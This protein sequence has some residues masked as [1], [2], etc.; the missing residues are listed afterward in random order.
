[1]PQATSISGVG[2][3]LEGRQNPLLGESLVAM[4]EA[5]T[6]VKQAEK[7]QALQKFQ[8]MVS[9][10]DKLPIDPGAMR[11]AAKKA[12]IP[13]A[14]DDDIAAI[15]QA[16]KTE[17]GGAAPAKQNAQPASSSGA[18]P[19][20]G[21]QKQAQ[22]DAAVAA[23]QKKFQDEMTP[24]KGL[25]HMLD[26]WLA[27]GQQ[28]QGQ[29]FKSKM[30]KMEADEATDQYSKASEQ[31]KLK[32]LN[33]DAKAVGQAQAMALVPFNI[34]QLA[35]ANAST[36]LKNKA[37]EIALGYDEGQNFR[38]LLQGGK[39]VK[40]AYSLAHTLSMGQP[41]SPEQMKAASSMSFKEMGDEAST[42]DNLMQIGVPANDIS[43]VMNKARETGDLPGALPSKLT[44]I[45]T[46]QLD[47]HKKQIQ[48]DQ[49]RAG[50]EAKRV[51]LEDRRVS[52]YEKKTDA[53]V[54]NMQWKHEAAIAKLHLAEVTG[55]NKEYL[56]S[57]KTLITQK[58][59]GIEID[60]K[61]LQ[62]TLDG[63]K[64][65]TDDPQELF[66]YMSGQP[67]GT[68]AALGNP[69]DDELGGKK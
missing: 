32:A 47:L 11:K 2:A 35:F 31:I 7:A 48:A 5:F 1:M 64:S 46:Q 14:S 17:R 49:T 61:E 43:R 12:G 56:D 22:P 50:A 66:N 33:G 25:Q 10:A 4:A 9:V 8:T 69:V 30:A 44:P 41:M 51:E 26:V 15:A 3:T 36:E 52:S 16:G 28:L 45:I 53:D 34:T 62:K 24:Q 67:S 21:G 68:P 42:M 63:L 19:Q 27:R 40:D 65:Y 55:E 6:R 29:E 20:G 58:K 57:L 60:P 38:A 23:A 39:S 37:Y 18:Q 59:A 13:L 54:K